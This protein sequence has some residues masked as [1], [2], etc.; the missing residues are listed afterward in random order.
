MKQSDTQQKQPRRRDQGQLLVTFKRFA[1]FLH[2]YLLP[3]RGLLIGLTISLFSAIGLQLATPLILQRFIDGAV[4]HLSLEIL[5]LIAAAYIGVAFLA[6]T[7]Q[8]V[9]SYVAERV[10]WI[11]TNALRI[12]AIRNCL[13]L[14]LAFYHEHT[15]GELVERVDGDISTLNNFF[16][17]FVIVILANT[18]L[19]LG[20]LIILL[21][22]DWLIGL[23]ISLYTLCFLLV[24]S[25]FASVST[26]YFVK[27]RQ[28][29]ADLSGL[30]EEHLD[31]TEDIR[32]NGAIEF[33]L[34]RLAFFQR[35]RLKA[36]RKAAAV[37]SALSGVRIF[38]Y[39]L[40][41]TIALGLSAY[42][43]TRS[44]ITI[45]TVYLVYAFTEM[46]GD[47]LR[48][49]TSEIGGFQ[50]AS[51]SLSRLDELFHIPSEI[52]SGACEELPEGP[53]SVTFQNVTFSY[54][55]DEARLHNISFHL[56]PGQ[57]L[58]LLGPTGSGKTTLARLLLRFYT[59]DGGSIQLGD[60]NI[61]Q[62]S[63]DTL[64][65]RVALVTQDVQLLHASLR[66]NLTFFDTTITDS[67]II[68]A[69]EALGLQEW[70]HDLPDGLETMLTAGS[71]HLSAGQAQL[72]ALTR[73]FLSD[74]DVIVLDEPSSRLDPLTEARLDHA[75][76]NLLQGRTGIIIAHRLSTVQKVDTI[77][78][79]EKGRIN[80]YGPRAQLEADPGSHYARLLHLGLLEETA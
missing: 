36:E 14:N 69:L 44:E 55:P 23:T 78:I 68:A 26:P 16:S 24:L 8:A 10:G 7:V 49:I 70:Y 2:T 21:K 47:P 79:L 28:S 50:Q 32:G 33:V 56:A 60:V 13:H 59:P 9:E 58:G 11:A 62:T 72:V 73:I 52:D 57:V 19:M 20:M 12:N 22:I 39:I 29:D 27:A 1:P 66:D 41:K 3:Q 54:H 74:P 6:K 43:Y 35:Q 40:G 18:F 51:A 63:V 42:L 25:R 5:I 4:A 65:S 45:G 64:R 77:L 61:S 17:R 37:N 48:K 30:L 15:P 53:L 67:K 76:A 71:N 38:F 31:S 75:F 80:E 34:G 46:L